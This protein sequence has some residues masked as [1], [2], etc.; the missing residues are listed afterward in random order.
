MK[1]FRFMS[2]LVTLYFNYVY[3]RT[4]IPGSS[5]ISETP[6]STFVDGLDRL[7]KIPSGTVVRLVVH[8]IQIMSNSCSSVSMGV[9]TFV[10]I[11]ALSSCHAMSCWSWEHAHSKRIDL[12]MQATILSTLH[13]RDTIV[14]T[15]VTLTHS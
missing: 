12:A 14:S 4:R 3:Q 1:I 13:I 6:D 9:E 2:D 15:S 7:Q 11:T 8:F 5:S 10:Y